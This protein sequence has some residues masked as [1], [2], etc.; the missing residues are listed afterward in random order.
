VTMS[1]YMETKIK[2]HILEK[3]KFHALEYIFSAIVAKQFALLVFPEKIIYFV[4]YQ[5]ILLDMM[6]YLNKIIKESLL[7]WWN[8]LKM[9]NIK[10]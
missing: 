9:V 10:I 8:I 2:L 7:K 5:S 1:A 6:V 3:K 4:N